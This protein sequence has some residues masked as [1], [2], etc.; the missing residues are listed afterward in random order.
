MNKP[1][2]AFSL[3]EVTLVLALIVLLTAIAYPTLDGLQRD[4]RLSAA[5][6]QVRAHWALAQ[7]RASPSLAPP[8]KPA[9]LRCGAHSLKCPS[10]PRPADP[11]GPVTRPA[12]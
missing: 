12:C 5:A 2:A 11:R 9:L 4:L 6:D 10:P 7:V 3:L 8:A 1:R